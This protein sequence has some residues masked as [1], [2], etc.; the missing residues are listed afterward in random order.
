MNADP[1]TKS[2]APLGNL[3]SRGGPPQVDST[4]TSP[5]QTRLPEINPLSLQIVLEG[6]LKS[7]DSENSR[8]ANWWQMQCRPG[9]CLKIQWQH[10]QTRCRL[11]VLQPLRNQQSSRLPVR[12]G[13]PRARKSEDTSLCVSSC[14]L[15]VGY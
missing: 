8:R 13:R 2:P 12:S 9:C 11:V 4:N 1:H 15:Q 7:D 10:H 5:A 3:L 6:R 14:S